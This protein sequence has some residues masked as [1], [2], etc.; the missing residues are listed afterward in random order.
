MKVTVPAAAEGRVVA[1]RVMLV[2]ATGFVL[3]AERVVVV[4]VA[5]EVKVTLRLLTTKLADGEK[6]PV[7]VPVRRLEGMVP[8][9]V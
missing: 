4:A 8:E 5:E 2:P 3:E 6:K 1:V 9:A 7:W